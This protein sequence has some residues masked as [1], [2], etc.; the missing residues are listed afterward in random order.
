M[1]N[2]ARVTVYDHSREPTTPKC[3]NMVPK[4]KL[5]R[6][7]GTVVDLSLAI[8]TVHS[9]EGEKWMEKAECWPFQI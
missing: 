7:V 9:I 5:R 3:S 8:A 4:E 1:I 6:V 2:T